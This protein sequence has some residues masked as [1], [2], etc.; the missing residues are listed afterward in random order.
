MLK[1]SKAKPMISRS[2]WIVRSNLRLIDPDTVESVDITNSCV[3]IHAW[4]KTIR[5]VKIENSVVM[6]IKDKRD[7][8]KVFNNFKKYVQKNEKYLLLHDNNTNTE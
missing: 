6:F 4:C 5:N 7:A 1:T 8:Q 3:Y 2:L